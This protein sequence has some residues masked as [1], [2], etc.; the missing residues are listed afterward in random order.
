M[1]MDE[2]IIIDFIE[3]RFGQTDKK[4]WMEGNCYYFAKILQT[5]FPMAVLYYDVVNGHFVSKIGEAFY[6]CNGFADIVSENLVHWD[7]Y[8]DIS[9]KKRIIEACIL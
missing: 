9:H 6:D 7:T 3:R 4:Q 1:D 8:S 5:R 2:N